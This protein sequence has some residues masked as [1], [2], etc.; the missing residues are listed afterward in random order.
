LKKVAAGADRHDNLFQGAV[1]GSLAQA[2]DGAFHLPGPFQ[3]CRQAVGHRHAQVVVTVNAQ[4]H[5]VDAAHVLFQVGDGGSVLAGHGI[6]DRVG[7]VDGGGAGLDG[8]L[9][10]LGQEVQLGAGGVL[11]RELDVLA[12]T[13]GPLDPF[14]S[15]TNNLLLGHLQ[16]ELAVDGAGSQEDVDTRPVGIAQGLPGPVDVVVVAAR[17]AADDRALD[18][19][20]DGL[21]RLEVARRGDG[22]AGLDHVHAQI[23]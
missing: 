10:H 20:G 5:L 17:Q 1:A 18:L 21:H 14:D 23:V 11:G 6:A 2:V 16:L 13:A 3:D 22:K 15:P 7:N 19:P 4:H 12:V 9:D 8:A